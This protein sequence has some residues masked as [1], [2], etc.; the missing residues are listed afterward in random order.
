MFKKLIFV[1]AMLVIAMPASAVL[2]DYVDAVLPVDVG[3]SSPASNTRAGNDDLWAVRSVFA[4]NGQIYEAGGN[5][6]D[7]ANPENA[8]RLKTSVVVPANPTGLGYNVYAYFWCDTSQWRI[9]ASLTNDVGELPLFI[10]YQ[11]PSTLT[12]ADGS[13]FVNAVLTREG[14]RQLW[15]AY[16]GTTG[17]GV[18]TGNVTIGVYIDD[19]A[20]HLTGNSRTWYD[21]IGYSEV[22]P[23]P[24]TIALLGLGGLALLRKKRA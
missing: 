2:I 9:R 16:L 5:F 12:T 14:N 20:A 13:E 17:V 4:N 24:A 21:G 1:L 15:Q 23:E 18:M 3:N 11:D 22:V 10:A 7:T 6:G 19:D 8:L